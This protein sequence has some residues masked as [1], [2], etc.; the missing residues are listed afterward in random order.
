MSRALPRVAALLLAASLVAGPVADACA[1]EVDDY[2]REALRRQNV[3]GA[4]VAVC[5]DG[6]LLKAEGYGRANVELDA[7]ATPQTVCQLASMTKPFMAAGV[8]LL[9]ED[10]QVLQHDKSLSCMLVVNTLDAVRA[11][12]LVADDALFKRPVGRFGESC[13]EV[14]R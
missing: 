9:V 8:M 5:R 13:L 3:P 4:S 6:R 1:D 10:I 11:I 2:V 12:V 14:P 7:P